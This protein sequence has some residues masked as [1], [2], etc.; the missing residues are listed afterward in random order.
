MLWWIAAGVAVGIAVLAG[1]ADWRRDRR[2]DLD[3]VGWVDWRST[4]MFA[5]IAAAGCA[6]VA[7]HG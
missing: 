1:V 5:L 7:Q 2:A 3:R 6:I 4:Q